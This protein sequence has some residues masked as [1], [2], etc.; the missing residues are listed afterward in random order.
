MALSA[1]LVRYGRI[2]TAG[3][4]LLLATPAA[5]AWMEATMARHM[6]LQMPLLAASGFV[7]CRLLPE[8]RQDFL[9]AAA[10][11]AIPCLLLAFFASG[12]WMLPRALDGALANPLNEAVKFFSLALL[13]GLPLGLAWK[14]LGVIGRSFVWTNII[15]MLVVLGWLYINAPVRLCNNYLVGQQESAGWGMVKLA[16]LLF[17][18]WLGSFFVGGDRARDAR[19]EPSD[20]PRPAQENVTGS[21]LGSSAR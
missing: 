8:R 18:G 1:S 21:A 5:R 4:Y 14:R 7:L 16:A 3:V 2:A 13:V 20:R 6:L 19:T 15:S 12:Y 10:G 9:L 17:A 11:G